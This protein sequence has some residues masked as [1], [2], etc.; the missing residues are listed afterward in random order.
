MEE[1]KGPLN[2]NLAAVQLAQNRQEHKTQ[3]ILPSAYTGPVL[4]TKNIK[5]ARPVSTNRRI[6]SRKRNSVNPQA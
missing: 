6:A 4:R 2:L 1:A 3:M 5:P